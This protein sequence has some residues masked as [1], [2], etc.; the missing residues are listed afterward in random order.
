MHRAL[1]NG[2]NQG[3]KR[4]LNCYWR[5]RPLALRLLPRS[6]VCVKFAR[7]LLRNSQRFPVASREVPGHIDDLPN[8]IRIMRN[9]PVDSLRHRVFL[10]CA[11]P[12]QTEKNLVYYFCGWA[13]YTT[14]FPKLPNI[15]SNSAKSLTPRDWTP[16][17][18]RY[19]HSIQ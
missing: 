16:R 5:L 9:L 14:F 13:R 2:M 10:L 17:K 18:F 7:L 3:R 15:W 6:H 12:E 19:I 11:P 4:N 1:Y 8:M